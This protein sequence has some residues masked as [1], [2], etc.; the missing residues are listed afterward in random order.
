MSS[1]LLAKLVQKL[2]K[3][4]LFSDPGKIRRNRGDRVIPAPKL[5]DLIAKLTEIAQISLK[6]QL[7]SRGKRQ[8][9]RRGEI[10]RERFLLPKA[11]HQAFKIHLLMR[12]VLIN[13]EELI[14]VFDEPIGIEEL[15]Y[16]ALLCPCS[17]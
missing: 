13:E 2:Q 12:S 5:A 15:P 1:A 17:L 16:D 11:L 9:D 10:L 4:L 8:D 14:P 7:L 6:D 3:E